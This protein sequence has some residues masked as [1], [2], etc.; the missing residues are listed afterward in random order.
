VRDLGKSGFVPLAVGMGPD[1]NLDVAIR[2]EPDVG[3]LVAGNDGTT[4]GRKHRRS[5]RALLDEEGEAYADQPPVGLGL[6]LAGAHLRQANRLDG[7]A[8]TFRMIAAVEMLAQHIVERHLVRPDH[9]AQPTFVRFEP[10]FT[11]NR[12]HDHFDREANA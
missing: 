6:L 8:Q 3:L 2:R 5:V 4:P 7:A 11:G 9:V 10:R 12:I 1:T